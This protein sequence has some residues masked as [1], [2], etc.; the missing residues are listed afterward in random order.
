M[1]KALSSYLTTGLA[2]ALLVYSASRSVD[3]ISATLPPDQQMLAFFGL[4]ALDGGL[5]A[6]LLF[7]LSGARGSWQRAIALIMIAVDFVGAV[8]MFTLDTL[9]RS[10]QAGMV[11]TLDEGIIR[12]A[13]LGL[14][15]VIAAN[16][17]SAIMSHITDP[18]ARK[19]AA[20]EE[21]TD[22]I[23]D[24]AIQQIASGARSLAAD[25]APKMAADWMDQTKSRYVALL[26]EGNGHKPS[27]V[28]NSEVV[29]K[30]PELK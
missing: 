14:S 4:A 7:F 26:N 8:A 22:I 3:F 2:L 25:L 9:Y 21:A 6:W 28:F 5:V 29:S 24:L 10:G 19:S 16:I 13:V 30:A 18:E 27:R 15:V 1:K 17:G 11:A 20:A 23:E 12:T